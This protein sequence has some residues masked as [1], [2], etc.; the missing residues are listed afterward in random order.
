MGQVPWKNSCVIV[1]LEVESPCEGREPG[2]GAG[3]TA[4]NLNFSEDT[5]SEKRWSEAGASC[6]LRTSFELGMKSQIFP[7]I[8]LN[9]VSKL[10]F[11]LLLSCLDNGKQKKYS[12]NKKSILSRV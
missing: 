2:G 6:V 5:S 1:S 10:G 11:L 9:K 8:K 7:Q 3:A 12:Y 4:S